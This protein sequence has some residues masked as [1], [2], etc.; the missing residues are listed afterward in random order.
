MYYTHVLG[1]TGIDRILSW[2]FLECSCR[3]KTCHASDRSRSILHHL[4]HLDPNLLF[5][6]AVQDLCSTY[7]TRKHAIDHADC[8]IV[9]LPPGNMRQIIQ[10]IQIR[11]PSALK[12]QEH[13]WSKN[14]SYRWLVQVVKPLR[15]HFPSGQQTNWIY[16]GIMFTVH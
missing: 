6:G 4:H 14:R 9:W 1:T 12:D 16:Y 7:P 10:I 8:I 11:N 15:R 13:A 2:N 5:W 3:S